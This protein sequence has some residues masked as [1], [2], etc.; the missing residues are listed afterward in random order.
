MIKG[1]L[2]L[3]ICG[4]LGSIQGAV[5]TSNMLLSVRFIQI[6]LVLQVKPCAESESESH[7]EIGRKLV[8]TKL[9]THP[10]QQLIDTR[11]D[12]KDVR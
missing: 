6:W 1:D 2:E 7:E 11:K 10:R 3:W 9:Q 4:L 5:T 8:R 12:D